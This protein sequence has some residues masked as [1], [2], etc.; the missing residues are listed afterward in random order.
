ML[1]A[2]P[3]SPFLAGPPPVLGTLLDQVGCGQ[4]LRAGAMAEAGAPG[5]QSPGQVPWG[6]FKRSL[7]ASLGC[8]VGQDTAQGQALDGGCGN[9]CP[10]PPLGS[11][12]G[13]QCGLEHL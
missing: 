10:T 5:T 7:Q 12:H 11:I 2:L 13:T 3:P 9:R 1:G 8:K 6:R 4:M